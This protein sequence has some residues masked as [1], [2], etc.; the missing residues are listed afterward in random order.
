MREKRLQCLRRNKVF[1]FLA[2]A[3]GCR[4]SENKNWLQQNRHS[5]SNDDKFD[6]T[7]G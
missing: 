3:Q 2:S 4:F 7:S 5:H 1:I 6:V